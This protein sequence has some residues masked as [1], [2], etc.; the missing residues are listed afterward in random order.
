MGRYGVVRS[1]AQWSQFPKRVPLLSQL[2]QPG[3]QP[4]E[5]QK[6]DWPGLHSAVPFWHCTVSGS[7]RPVRVAPLPQS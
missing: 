1:D 7:S 2:A 3:V 5:N 6:T 4:W